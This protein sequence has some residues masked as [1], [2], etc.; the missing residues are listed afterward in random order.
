VKRSPIALVLLAASAVAMGAIACSSAPQSALQQAPPSSQDDNSNTGGTT[1]SVA[2]T[3]PPPAASTA[4]P[5]T[6]VTTPAPTSSVPSV[7]TNCAAATDAVTCG[8]CCFQQHN[9]AAA[10][11]CTTSA[12]CASA[13]GTSL[14]TGNVP[15][16]EC[17]MCLPSSG[18]DINAILNDQTDMN[19]IQQCVQTSGCGQKG[20]LPAGGNGGNGNGNG[21]FPFGN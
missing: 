12:K 20:G 11:A 3:T 7:L 16:L 18:C 4:P 1:S 5:A 6:S 21:G 9:Q 13:C 19:A 2:S 15:S 14:C 10:C 17:I 8:Q